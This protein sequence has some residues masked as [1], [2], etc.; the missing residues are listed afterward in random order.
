M[1]LIMALVISQVAPP[2]PGLQPSPEVRL[3]DSFAPIDLA[4][5]PVFQ[6]FM[7]GFRGPFI[8]SFVK[9]SRGLAP[10]ERCIS[11]AGAI[12]FNVVIEYHFGDL[13]ISEAR[14]LLSCECDK[15]LLKLVNYDEPLRKK[16]NDE[17]RAFAIKASENKSAY[18]VGGKQ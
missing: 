17:L 18:V 11:E 16:L 5:G 8:D 1:F 4:Q 13:T 14:E 7:N 9:S 3:K 15:R 2:L 10:T 12:T 6:S